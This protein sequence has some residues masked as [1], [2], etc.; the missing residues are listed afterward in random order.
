[1]CTPVALAAVSVAQTYMGIKAQNE[2]A[3]NMATSG[4]A[5]SAS[6]ILAAR[7]Q[8]QQLTEAQGDIRL[9][10]A[11][12][13]TL[14]IRQG[15]RDRAFITAA[16]SEGVGSSRAIAAASIATGEDLGAIE[17]SSK[18]AVAQK[19]RE[20]RG[21]Y[22]GTQSRLNDIESQVRSVP[23]VSPLSAMLQLGI[24]GF[25][26]Y[27]QGAGLQAKYGGSAAVPRAT[28]DTGVSMG[29]SMIS[30]PLQTIKQYAMRGVT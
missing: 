14:R 4:A 30:S 15:L 26:G 16:L 12:R 11:Q 19:Q 28:P 23:S 24:A 5:A 2:A 25:T 17:A 20:K 7:E 9:E 1:M 18:S 21:I 13:K 6:S 3:S 10:A 29:V 8:Y 22:T 27:N